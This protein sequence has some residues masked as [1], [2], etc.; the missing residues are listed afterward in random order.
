[1]TNIGAP[2]EVES[3]DHPDSFPE[4]LEQLKQF[5]DQIKTAFES[6]N[7]DSA[8]DALHE[9]GH[10]LE[11]LPELAGKLTTDPAQTA[12]V[13]EAQTKLFDAYGKLDESM[14]GQKPEPFKYETVAADVDAA[15]EA[16]SKISH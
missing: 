9:I 3:H 6:G 12:S 13:V 2:P 7:P 1:V 10:V 14:H 15:F 8:H 4:A 5:K 16:L 11:C